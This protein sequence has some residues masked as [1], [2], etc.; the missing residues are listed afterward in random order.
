M[1]FD[2]RLAVCFAA[3][4]EELSFTRAAIRLGVAQPWISE[5]V[6]K[7]EDQIG[8]RLLLRTSR[9]VEL[10]AEGAKFLAFAQNIAKS[11]TDAQDFIQQLNTSSQETLRIGALE[12]TLDSPERAELI[13]RFITRFPAVQ[14]DISHGVMPDL[15]GQLDRQEVDAVLV[16]GQ[17]FAPS[18]DLAMVHYSKRI[19]HVL[20]PIE[21]ELSG[22][23]EI[24]LPA[25]TG[26]KLV[27]TRGKADPLV[28]QYIF[29]TFK[30]LEIVFA[31]DPHRNTIVDF[32]RIRRLVCLMWY[33]HRT[34]RT[35]IGDMVAI[36]IQGV[37]LRLDYVVLY[38]RR[39]VHRV[40]QR[41]CKVAQQIDNEHKNSGDKSSDVREAVPAG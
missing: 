35:V 23:D 18:D 36:P 40:V 37:P 6:R 8:F 11:C 20:L 27:T 28:A 32:A 14:L 10:T 30:G 4:A 22:L 34:Q 19:G 5:R 13:N 12:A 15:L 17:S 29:K 41:F 31:P 24:P 33:E 9:R 2:P 7:L 21:D 39:L 16:F 1:V 25:L 26:R 3:V 38:K